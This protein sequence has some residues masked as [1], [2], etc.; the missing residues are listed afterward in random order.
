MMSLNT[1]VP[2]LPELMSSNL[3]KMLWPAQ[4]GEKN[5]HLIY[6]CVHEFKPK[7]YG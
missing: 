1:V 3:W 6:G 4:E 7:V 5:F 2:A